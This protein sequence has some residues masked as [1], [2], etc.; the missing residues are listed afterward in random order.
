VRY[1]D[2]HGRVRQYYAHFEGA[3]PRLERRYRETESDGIR[4]DI[5]RYMTSNPCPACRGKR[6]KPE[7][8]AVTVA[9][10]NI[11]DGSGCPSPG[12]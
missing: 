12:L 9:G 6:L 5:E 4:A 3:V 10:K 1:E 2:R 11:M 8:L 7:S